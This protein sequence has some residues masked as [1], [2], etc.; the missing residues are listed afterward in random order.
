MFVRLLRRAAGLS[1]VAVLLVLKMHF[2]AAQDRRVALVVGNG[3]YRNVPQLTNPANDARLMARTL[4]ALGFKLIGD[5]AMVDL[6]KTSFDAA[7]RT[8]GLELQGADVGLFYY[9]GHGLQVQGENWLVPMDANPTR[10]QDLDFQMV[11]ASLVL[12]QMEGAGTKLNL[13]ILDACRNNP[14]GGRGLRGTESGLAQMRAPEGTLIS[15]ATQPGNTALDGTGVNS[16]YTE[17]LAETMRQPG[18]DVLRMFNRVGVAVKKA[19]GGAQQPWVSS[20]PLDTDY[21]LAGPASNPLA[22]APAVSP[23]TPPVAPPVAQRPAVDTASVAQGMIGKWRYADGAACSPTHAGMID[24]RNG[25]II[26]E[27]RRA[28]GLPNIAMER[29]DSV[30]GNVIYTTVESDQN[31]STPETGSRMRYLIDGDSWTSQ[32][33]STGKAAVHHRC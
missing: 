19:T 28:S 5:A 21:V 6:D 29:I 30:S 9:S 18:L 10:V 15:Y 1:L 4:Q 20:S 31:T 23:V 3:A 7:V 33:L 27:W 24:I 12:K 25:Y 17:A 26:F 11:D 8:F 14:F 13:M 32:N 22:G 2:A 16:P